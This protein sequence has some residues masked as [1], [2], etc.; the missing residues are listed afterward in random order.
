MDPDGEYTVNFVFRFD[1]GGRPAG[2]LGMCLACFK[3]VR[4]QQP[5]NKIDPRV[6][7]SKRDSRSAETGA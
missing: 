5:E 1:V 7:F 4:L 6:I 2:D 3:K